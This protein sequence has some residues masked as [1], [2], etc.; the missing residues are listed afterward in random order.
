MQVLKCKE[1]QNLASWEMLVA[2]EI[3][4]QPL[5]PSNLS[6]KRANWIRAG[7]RVNEVLC[8]SLLAPRQSPGR[9]ATQCA[10]F[11]LDSDAVVAL[12]NDDN[13]DGHEIVTITQCYPH[14]I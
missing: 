6:N 8:C 1:L 4:F 2:C 3:I 5:V 10:S 9:L 12:R 7:S 11:Y 14:F 13:L